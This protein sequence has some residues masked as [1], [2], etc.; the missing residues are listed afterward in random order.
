MEPNRSKVIHSTK[1]AANRTRSRAT[2][3]ALHKGPSGSHK[4]RHRQRELNASRAKPA[5]HKGLSSS[6]ELRHR[7]GELG[8]S[9]ALGLLPTVAASA[10]WGGNTNQA[11]ETAPSSPNVGLRQLDR[12]LV[13]QG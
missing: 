4:A 12:G 3:P 11:A 10:A 1:H 2:K 9:R 7:K 8:T 13:R 6:H 5:P